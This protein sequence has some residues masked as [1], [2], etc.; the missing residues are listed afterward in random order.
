MAAV[1]SSPT[2]SSTTTTTTWTSGIKGMAHMAIDERGNCPAPTSVT[3]AEEEPEEKEGMR[4][5]DLGWMELA[6]DGEAALSLMQVEALQFWEMKRKQEEEDM[7]LARMLEGEVSTVK[8]VPPHPSQPDSAW[9]ERELRDAELAR[10]LEDEERKREEEDK[11][12]AE[13]LWRQ[14]Q[15]Q[16]RERRRQ[17]EIEETLTMVRLQAKT[18]S[19]E[20]LARALKEKEDLLLELEEIKARSEMEKHIPKEFGDTHVG[21]TLNGI[22]FPEKWVEQRSDYH[23]FDVQRNSNEWRQIEQHFTSTVGGVNCNIQ[24]IE[25][26]QN[27]TLWTFYYLK[28]NHVALNN[29]Q[30]PNEQYLFHGSRVDAYETILKDGFD[31]RVANM[32]GSIGAGIYFATHAATSTAY[33]T[34]AC[35]K[36]MLYCRVTLGSVG[37]GKTGLRRPP[38]KRGGGLHDSVG[39]ANGGNGMYVVFDNYQAFPEYTIYYQ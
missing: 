37:V 8:A 3:M 4:E 15:E 22:E 12:L 30:H 32:G 11:R 17:K 21:I 38:E 19:D 1:P 5:G 13:E 16:E 6:D 7:R 20:E 27:K 9:R 33:V 35:V 14:E 39:Q 10:Q 34:N 24:R 31:H 28:R 25:R 2:V 29:N 23:I 36:K 26:N 18:E